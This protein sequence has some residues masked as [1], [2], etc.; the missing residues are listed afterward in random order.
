MLGIPFLQREE[1]TVCLRER[2]EGKRKIK[3]FVLADLQIFFISFVEKK[4]GASRLGTPSTRRS[5]RTG[6]RTPPLS[7]AGRIRTRRRLNA[8]CVFASWL[9]C[10]VCGHWVKTVSAWIS[11]LKWHGWLFFH[12][13]VCSG[14]TS[15]TY[16]TLFPYRHKRLRTYN[17]ICHICVHRFGK[18]MRRPY[19]RMRRS[20]WVYTSVKEWALLTSWA[21]DNEHCFR[22]SFGSRGIMHLLREDVYSDPFAPTIIL[23]LTFFT[24]M[25]VSLANR[26][27]SGAII[28]ALA[29]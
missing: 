20:L 1:R 22:A 3:D 19:S 12:F 28:P 7:T 26:A 2:N 21:L 16:N 15:V 4:T 11:V 24:P 10:E 29:T 8:L 13:C 14:T 9:L 25:P 5:Y 6:S 17:T 23:S 18:K 27:V